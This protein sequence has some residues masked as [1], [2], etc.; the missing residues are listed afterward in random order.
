MHT[1]GFLKAFRNEEL[2]NWAH[3]PPMPFI[4][5]AEAAVLSLLLS[6][7]EGVVTI[8]VSTQLGHRQHSM[9]DKSCSI[10]EARYVQR[11]SVL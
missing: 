10:W 8:L 3:Y 2:Q 6:P 5:P 7:K 1:E 9:A 4:S 11:G